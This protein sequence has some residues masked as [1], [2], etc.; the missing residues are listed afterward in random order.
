MLAA[1]DRLPLLPLTLAALALGIAPV[2]PEPHLWEKLRLLSEGNLTRPI[3]IFD[4]LMHGL[5]VLVL[6]LR[7]IRMAKASR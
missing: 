4:L 3:D 1:L 7:L 2:F 5:P 6:A